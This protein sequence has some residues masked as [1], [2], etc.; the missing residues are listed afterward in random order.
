ME[1]A[2]V[3]LTG[4]P[5]TGKTTVARI[6]KDELTSRDVPTMF[7]DSDALR[8][9]MMPAPSGTEEERD[10][11]YA[12]LGHVAALGAEGGSVVVV[13]AAAPKRIYRDRVR[14]RVESFVEVLLICDP[15]ILELRGTHAVSKPSDLPY[16]DPRDPEL[17]FDSGRTSATEIAMAILRLLQKRAER[18]HRDLV[19]LNE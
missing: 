19:S 12:T 11:F 13:A 17:I 6:L 1:G 18:H 16:E 8:A 4:I 15:E 7:L 2:V 5:A 10:V 3:W 14:Q 9:V